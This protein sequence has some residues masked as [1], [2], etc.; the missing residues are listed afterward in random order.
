M[1]SKP[2]PKTVVKLYSRLN[3]WIYRLSGGRLMNT[4]LG[5]PIC[6]VTMT[7]RKSGKAITQPLMYVPHGRDILLVASQGGAPRHPVW[8]HNLIAKPQVSI[9][10]G[11]KRQAMTV[12]QAC[13]E[14][15]RILWPVCVAAYP[16]YATYQTLTERDIPVM[17]CLPEE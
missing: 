9:Q 3:T 13:A 8:Y 11:S 2:P 5:K 10:V 12:R 4:M 14:E 16:D 1:A 15:K 7:G 17:I 6:L